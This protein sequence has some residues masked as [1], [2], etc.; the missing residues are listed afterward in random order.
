[1]DELQSYFLSTKLKQLDNWTEKR[2]KAAKQYDQILDS[3]GI[4]RTTSDTGRHVYHIYSVLV[5]NR[6][7]VMA[8]LN[9][10]GIGA[11]SHYPIPCHL[12]DGYKPFI[13]IGSELKVSEDISSKLLS[14]PLDESI[15]SEQIEYVCEE[16][17]KSIKSNA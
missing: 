16:L 9:A 2:I 15:S 6:D 12:Q 11:G 3:L 1:M 10:K 14:L 13:E 8:D 5:E 4:Q 7:K 17:V